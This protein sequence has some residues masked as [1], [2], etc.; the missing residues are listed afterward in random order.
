MNRRKTKKK[1]GGGRLCKEIGIEEKKGKRNL[2]L[3]AKG[4]HVVCVH[5]RP[6]KSPVLCIGERR[7]FRSNTKDT[8]EGRKVR[9]KKK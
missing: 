3:T 6:H 7:G 5:N 4:K 1:K 2:Q 8:G 9:R